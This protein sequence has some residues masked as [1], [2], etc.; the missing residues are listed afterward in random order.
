MIRYM[1]CP[2]LVLLPHMVDHSSMCVV[3]LET[4]PETEKGKRSKQ[5]P[6]ECLESEDEIFRITETRLIDEKITSVMVR[7]VIYML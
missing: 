4:S 1:S 2:E 6:G 5:G 7:C 3:G